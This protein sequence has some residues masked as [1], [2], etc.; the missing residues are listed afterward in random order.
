[1]VTITAVLTDQGNDLVNAEIHG[2]GTANDVE[3]EYA[4]RMMDAMK[5]V[6]PS[7]RKSRVVSLTDED[8]TEELHGHAS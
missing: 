2:R 6:T 7:T 1:M 5:N 4:N 8:R 3:L